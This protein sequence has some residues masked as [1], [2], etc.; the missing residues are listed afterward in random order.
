MVEIVVHGAAPEGDEVGGVPREVVPAVILNRLPQSNEEPRPERH[1]VLSEKEGT[2][3]GSD[4]QEERLDG[5]SV[6]RG[7]PEGV[8]VLV[9]DL[10]HVL[11]HALVVQ[12]AVDPVKVKILDD[13]ESRELPRE[14][15]D[16]GQG[17]GHGEPEELRH[18]VEQQLHGEL[19]EHVREEKAL[20]ALRDHGAVRLLFGLDLVLVEVRDLV[21]HQP[22]D[23]R[24][25]VD[26]LVEHERQRPRDHE[27]REVI[28]HDAP[29]RGHLGV[30]QRLRLL[31]L[32]DDVAQ[33]DVADG[34][35]RR[36]G[37]RRGDGDDRGGEHRDDDRDARGIHGRVVSTT[38]RSNRV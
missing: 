4:A 22:R 30:H 8:R 18:P 6:L 37:V 15:S 34:N 24:A 13:E 3:Q 5:V 2:Q 23:P 35:R 38:M 12:S 32:G 19:D 14:V 1:H 26:E 11:V 20:E 33:R 28:Q 9:V 21:E 17:Q 16:R 31:Q 10:V 25:E 36:G 7:D 29:P 27:R